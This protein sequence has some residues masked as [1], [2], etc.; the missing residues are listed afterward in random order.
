VSKAKAIIGASIVNNEDLVGC[1]AKLFETSNTLFECHASVVD[2]DDKT[3]RRPLVARILENSH[4]L[5]IAKAGVSPGFKA[6][7]RRNPHPL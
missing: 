7:E 3:D 2:W 1:G 6:L 4:S 5:P